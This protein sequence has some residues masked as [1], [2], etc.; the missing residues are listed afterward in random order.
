MPVA[1]L[2]PRPK[3]RVDAPSAD[4]PATSGASAHDDEIGSDEGDTAVLARRLSKRLP[5]PLDALIDA[6]VAIEVD[7]PVAG[8]AVLAHLPSKRHVGS[9]LVLV[10]CMRQG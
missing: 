7:A 9:K 5:L 10:L 2:D 6:F 1:A 3:L 8:D 4:A